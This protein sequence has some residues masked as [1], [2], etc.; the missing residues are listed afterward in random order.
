MGEVI[1][2]LHR[3]AAAPAV[4][5]ADAILSYRDLADRVATAADTIGGERRLVMLPGRNDIA[6]LTAYLAALD[7]GHVVMPVPADGDHAAVVATYDPDAVVVAG[8][9][10]LRRR[11][12]AH[13]PHPDLRLLLSTSGST[14]SAKMVRL[15]R[16]NLI[17]NAAAIA[18]YLDIRAS[19]RAATTLPMS[20]CYG[21]SVVHSHLLRGGGLIL[22]ELSV[23]DDDFWQVFTAAGGTTFPG[24]PY[25]FELLERIG[26]DGSATPRLRYLTQAGGRLPADRVQR[27]AEVGERHGWQLVVMYGATEATAR[28]A[29]LPPELARR[30]PQAIGRPIPGG[31]FRLAPLPDWPADTGELVYA[32]PNVM[33]GYADG[34]ADLASGRLVDELRTGDIARRGDD[35]L[36][37]I[38]GRANRFAKLFGLRVD[39]QRVENALAAHGMPAL[40]AG[41]D[42]ALCVAVAGECDTGAVRETAARVAGVPAAAVLVAP[43]PDLPR[44]PS[45]KPDYPRVAAL[46]AAA[47]AAAAAPSDD[48]AELFAEVLHLP[49]AVVTPGSTFVALGGNSL[50]YVAMSVRLERLLGALP[51]DWPRL[52]V[53]DLQRHRRPRS[54]FRTSCET[55]VVL[56]AAA[57]VLIVVSHAE[58]AEVWGGAHILLGVAGYNFGRFCLTPLP[59]R[60]R[61]RHLRATIGWIAGPAVAWVA[62]ALVVTDDYQLSNLLLAN[63]FLGPHDS[64]TAGR[65]WFVEVLVWTL[66]LLAAVLWMPVADRWER[67]RPFGFALVALAVAVALRYDVLGLHLGYGAWFTMLAG[68]FFAVGWAASKATSHWQ[69]VLVS[70]VLLTCLVGYFDELQ[71]AVI[72][73]AGLLLLIWVPAIRCPAGVAVVA[74]ALAEASLYT[75]LTHFQV[76]ALFDGHPLPGVLT[77]LVVGVSVTYLV[78][79]IRRWWRRHRPAPPLTSEDR[80]STVPARSGRSAG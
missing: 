28:M 44:L 38:V 60:S 41:T 78:T 17:A 68:W 39:L 18:E 72:V 27:W 77:S 50:S 63:K 24:V 23:V 12:S 20:Y 75:Y 52:P 65:L 25:T 21:L 26:F 56:R 40:C 62:V 51:T 43:V 4:F 6:T 36:Y 16:Q 34:P 13:R 9:F 3:F 5:T 54:R 57:I 61:L 7:G 42:D 2:H 71:R 22:T 32:G 46:A 19:D 58:L 76:Y 14:G 55:S 70:A 69:R 35:G 74:G 31:R 29:Y 30:R 49:R 66:L 45:G 8:R 59:R 47:P 73:G 15:S 67:R 33:M 37:E 1:D 64:M 48:I 53:S 79:M 10:E 80:G 11:H